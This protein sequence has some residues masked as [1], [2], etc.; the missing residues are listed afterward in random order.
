MKLVCSLRGVGPLLK[1]THGWCAKPFSGS[2]LGL[3]SSGCNAADADGVFLR[4]HAFSKWKVRSRRRR[5][6][7]RQKLTFATRRLS[8]ELSHRRLCCA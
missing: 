5:R 8:V 4:N 1:G 2:I 7:R 3:C 6:R